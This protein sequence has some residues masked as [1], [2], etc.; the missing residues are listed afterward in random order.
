MQTAWTNE[1]FAPDLLPHQTDIVDLMLDQIVHMEQNLSQLGRNDFRLIAHRMELA[2]IK[3]IISSYLR[4]RLVKI[5]QFA[6]AILADEEKRS[7]DERRLSA[8]ERQFADAYVANVS[9]HFRHIA[10]R[11]MPLNLQETEAAQVVRPNVREHV[12]L[13]AIVSVSSV[14]VGRDDE[15]VDLVAGS[16]H[17]MPYNLA[18]ELVLDGR[19]QLI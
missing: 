16:R 14:V 15:E 3:Y 18:A 11:H 12:F 6:A 9:G 13:K 17:I 4:S 5:E 19:V 2:R 7:P 10:L 8:E 1:K